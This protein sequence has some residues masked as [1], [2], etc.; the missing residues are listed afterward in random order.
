ML[1]M[2][3]KYLNSIYELISDNVILFTICVGIFLIVIFHNKNNMPDKD[4]AENFGV[5]HAI[6]GS[7]QSFGKNTRLTLEL[8]DIS[9]GKV[10]WSD[11]VDFLL[12]DIF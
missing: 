10:I 8:N 7:F 9:K 5:K 1:I 12:D 11:K 4:I 2:L 6:Q 3:S